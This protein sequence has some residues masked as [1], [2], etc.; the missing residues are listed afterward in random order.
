M[1]HVSMCES[2]VA[3]VMDLIHDD[4]I[5]KNKSLSQQCHSVGTCQS[6]SSLDKDKRITG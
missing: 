2:I 1:C 6:I 3:P 5:A 4:L